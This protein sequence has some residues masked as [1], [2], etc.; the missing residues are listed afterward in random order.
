MPKIVAC[1]LKSDPKSIVY[2]N[3]D[4]VTH[5]VAHHKGGV[6]IYWAYSSYSVENFIDVDEDVASLIVRAE[7]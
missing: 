1:K 4:N 6:R 7:R 5:F 2:V 3:M